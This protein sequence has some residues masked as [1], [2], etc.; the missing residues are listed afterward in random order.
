M[1]LAT[2]PEPPTIEDH[3]HRGSSIGGKPPTKRRGARL[4][5]VSEIRRGAQKKAP[6]V[7]G[8]KVNTEE[9][10]LSGSDGP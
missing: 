3:P 9:A 1:R 10:R 7:S 8:A 6:P 4:V 5:S 2:D